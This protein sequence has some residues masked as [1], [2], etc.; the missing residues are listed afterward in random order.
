M[1]KLQ[2]YEMRSKDI[3]LERIVSQLE[4]RLLKASHDPDTAL[5]PKEK[6]EQNTPM[7]EEIADT[8]EPVSRP[9]SA[10][11]PPKSP[12]EESSRL[13]S[14]FSIVAGIVGGWFVWYAANHFV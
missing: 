12:L 6:S 8:R 14:L 5:M 11:T 13:W 1:G 4:H 10:I 7:I 3:V 9:V 2:E